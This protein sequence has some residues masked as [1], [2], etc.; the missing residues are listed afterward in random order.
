MNFSS[1]LHENIKSLV[2]KAY[3]DNLPECA[4][5]LENNSQTDADILDCG[6]VFHKTCSEKLRKPFCPCCRYPIDYES[7]D[8]PVFVPGGRILPRCTACGIVGHTRR[9]RRCIKYPFARHN[10]S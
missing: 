10:S 5:C 6:H 9:S 8:E 2:L 3:G 4:I 7:D 1:M